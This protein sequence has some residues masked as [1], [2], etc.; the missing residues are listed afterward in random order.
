MDVLT[1]W[2]IYAKTTVEVPA[3]FSDL[4]ACLRHLHT[5]SHLLFLLDLYL[6]LSHFLKIWNGIIRCHGGTLDL[7]DK[8]LRWCLNV[9]IRGKVRSLINDCLLYIDLLHWV[10]LWLRWINDPDCLLRG[11]RAHLWSENR[12]SPAHCVHLGYL[13][14][15]S[16]LMILTECHLHGKLILHLLSHVWI[17]CEPGSHLECRIY[18]I[19]ELLVLWIKLR[20]LCVMLVCC[21]WCSRLKSIA[22]DVHCFNL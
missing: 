1:V 9:K 6:L 12:R 16:R 14:W 17:T 22:I 3:F 20:Y 5:T 10:L 11:R 19:E 18:P 13:A 7:V 21:W 2:P 4:W 8:V 15:G